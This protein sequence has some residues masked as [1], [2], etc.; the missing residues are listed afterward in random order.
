MSELKVFLSFASSDNK[1]ESIRQFVHDLVPF[2]N[3]QSNRDIFFY[4][5]RV[6][7]GRLEETL[8]GEVRE[9]DILISV[10]SNNYLQ[11]EWCLSEFEEFRNV[12][13]RREKAHVF[14]DIDGVTLRKDYEQALMPVRDHLRARARAVLQVVQDRHCVQFFVKND[15]PGCLKIKLDPEIHKQEYLIGITR[16]RETMIMVCTDCAKKKAH[17]QTTDVSRVTSDVPQLQ[18]GTILPPVPTVIDEI[19]DDEEEGG[20]SLNVFFGRAHP[21]I[22]AKR[23]ELITILRAEVPT[24]RAI[25]DALPANCELQ[26]DHIVQFLGANAALDIKGAAVPEDFEIARV[27]N[28]ARALLKEQ[29]RG[30][31][32]DIELFCFDQSGYDLATDLEA[33]LTGLMRSRLGFDS[34]TKDLSDR[35]LK[36]VIDKTNAKPPESQPVRVFLNVND[37][38]L[39]FALQARDALSDSSLTILAPVKTNIPMVR[40]QGR[41]RNLEQCDAHLILSREDYDNGWAYSQTR[42]A[43][44]LRRGNPPR[45]N[46]IVA[47]KASELKIWGAAQGPMIEYDR[48]D[49]AP[50]DLPSVKDLLTQIKE[51]IDAP[52]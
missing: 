37:P 52:R 24:F 41:E 21:S 12:S 4:P 44:K 22:L 8:L 15:E 46:L 47:P 35:L 25:V 38:D 6:Q 11:S 42:Q 43:L 48:K 27:F 49:R 32:E 39:D 20:Q 10:L 50:I 5:D 45:K 13:G 16:I 51:T 1:R 19:F 29:D 34:F 14:I 9:S 7:V 18:S 40:L 23:E 30:W 17:S 33:A 3:F 36:K 28:D 2:Y 31:Q 26:L